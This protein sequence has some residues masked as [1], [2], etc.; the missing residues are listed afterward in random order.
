MKHK[1]NTKLTLKKLLLNKSEIVQFD[2]IKGGSE[3]NT[4]LPSHQSLNQ[5]TCPQDM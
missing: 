2:S 4:L 5:H 3:F 1:K